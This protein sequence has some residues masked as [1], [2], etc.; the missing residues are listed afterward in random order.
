MSGIAQ[1]AMVVG[2]AVLVA[3]MV[4]PRLFESLMGAGAAGAAGAAGGAVAGAWDQLL[5]DIAH[6][7]RIPDETPEELAARLAREAEYDRDSAAREKAYQE[8]VAREAAHSAMCAALDPYTRDM[9]ALSSCHM[10]LLPIPAMPPDPVA[11]AAAEAWARAQADARAAAL[12]AANPIDA[13]CMPA[14]TRCVS[15]FVEQCRR[16][17]PTETY[18]MR[19]YIPCGGG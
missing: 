3:V 5:A 19:S 15:G 14:D 10:P 17:S 1:D 4:L 18:W 9:A 8:L 13:Y 16:S 7:G 2:G 6:G 11:L 12:R